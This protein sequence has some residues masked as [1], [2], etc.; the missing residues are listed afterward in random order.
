MNSTYTIE[1][2]RGII[3]HKDCYL[4]SR[5]YINNKTK[6]SVGCWNCKNRWK[7]TLKQF[8]TKD[9]PC[10]WCG[11]N[12]TQHR[13]FEIIKSRF[14]DAL[15]NYR[16]F[17]WL[18]TSNGRQEI[19]IYVPSVKLAIEYDGEQHFHPVCFG[20]ISKQR[21]TQ[22]LVKTK[23]LDKRKNAAIKKHVKDVRYFIRFNYKERITAEYVFRKLQKVLDDAV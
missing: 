4:L 2:V 23:R 15:L 20:G 16:D 7:T 13:L 18:K 5:T 3:E 22:N 10:K 12:S 8:I 1:E 9:S 19:D 21:A 14:K 11:Y 6:L 17:E